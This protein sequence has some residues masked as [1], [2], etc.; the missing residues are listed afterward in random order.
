MNPIYSPIL[1]PTRKPSNQN[2]ALEGTDLQYQKQTLIIKDSHNISVSQEEAQVL[3][4]LELS[5]QAAI[6]AL[7]IAFGPKNDARINHLQKLVQ[8]IDSLQLQKEKI[9]ILSSDA[10]TITQAQLQVEVLIQAVIELLALITAKII[11][12]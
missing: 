12:L 6:Q 10:I 9:V 7:I 8:E 11:E 4:G 1:Q 3:V 5:L 2:Q